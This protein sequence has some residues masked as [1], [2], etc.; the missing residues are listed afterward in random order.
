ML[1]LAV[2]KQRNKAS[3]VAGTA[4]AML[5]H[6]SQ[7]SGSSCGTWSYLF[8]FAACPVHRV[9]V[10]AICSRGSGRRGGFELWLSQSTAGQPEPQTQLPEELT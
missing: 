4:G 1:W 8:P 9:K 6:P 3:A 7:G 10:A 2:C 5:T